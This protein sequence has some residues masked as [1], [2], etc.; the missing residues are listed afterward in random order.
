MP[1]NLAEKA[2]EQ[3]VE[4]EKGRPISFYKRPKLVVTETIRERNI[5][6]VS[7]LI[8]DRLDD[9][10][11]ENPDVGTMK[12]QMK[13]WDYLVDYYFRVELEGWEK[14]PASPTLIAGIHS[15]TWLTM[16]AWVFCALWWRQFGTQR[17]LHGT[18]HDMLFGMPGLGTYFK[19]VGVI[20]AGRQSVTAALETG[21]D[22]VVW[23]GGDIDA[24]RSW[25]KRDEVILGNRKGFVRQ[26]I[27]S[28][29]PIT[30]I[31]TT[32]GHDTVF[33]VSEGRW[34]AKKLRTKKWFRSEICPVVVGAPFG[35]SLE[36]LPMHIPLPSKIRIEILDPIDVGNDSD[37]ENDAEYVD[38]IYKEV[39]QSIQ[40]GVNRLAAKR[41][42]PIF[43]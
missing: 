3:V 33:V 16:D 6:S 13:I 2:A 43:G 29:V 35:L 8:K 40:A 18:A 1:T 14:L 5:E 12:A 25:K 42:F 38:S 37:K 21:H 19:K 22:V 31:A 20:P 39:E 36:V 32:G 41:K 17:T 4:K 23:P 27:R 9:W 24:M 34:L 10:T 30:P 28:G 11:V 7:E 15:G 26:A